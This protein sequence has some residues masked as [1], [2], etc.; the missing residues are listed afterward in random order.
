MTMINLGF[1]NIVDTEQ[2]SADEIAAL[3]EELNSD[4]VDIEEKLAN[5]QD[6]KALTGIGAS[7]IWVNKA[8]HALKA[9]RKALHA[10]YATQKQKKR[11]INQAMQTDWKTNAYWQ[12]VQIARKTLSKETFDTILSEAKALADAN[13]AEYV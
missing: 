1:N 8:Q 12:F 7:A 13:K 4:V 6:A 9:K 11:E 5:H 3:I 2:M 10:L